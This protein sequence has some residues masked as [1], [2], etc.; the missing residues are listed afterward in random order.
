MK[1][2]LLVRAFAGLLALEMLVTLPGIDN[3]AYAK[4]N[5]ETKTEAA[6]KTEKTKDFTQVFREKRLTAQNGQE[7]D[8]ELKVGKKAKA[9]KTVKVKTAKVLQIKDLT[10]INLSVLTANLFR[11]VV[12]EVREAKDQLIGMT[13]LM[14][15]RRI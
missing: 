2:K 15:K 8:K 5:G 12:K 9:I 3:I 13:F 7:K 4:S 14:K 10:D 11:K 6:K 1:K